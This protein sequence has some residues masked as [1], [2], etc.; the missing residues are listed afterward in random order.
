MHAYTS[1]RYKHSD[2]WKFIQSDVKCKNF[3]L[4]KRTQTIQITYAKQYFHAW[5]YDAQIVILEYSSVF[6]CF[7]EIVYSEGIA[8]LPAQQLGAINPWPPDTGLLDR[9]DDLAHKGILFRI[10]GS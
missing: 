4:Q 10:R 7:R 6:N 3:R 1:K 2:C 8:M 9:M 5:K